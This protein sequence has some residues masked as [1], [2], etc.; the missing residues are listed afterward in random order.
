MLDTLKLSK[1]LRAAGIDSNQADNIARAL[2][3]ALIDSRLMSRTELI[4]QTE[5]S[6]LEARLTAKLYVTAL[7]IVIVLAVLRHV[8]P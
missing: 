5:I 7:A 8:W 3:E 6:S 4:S 2:N 1:D